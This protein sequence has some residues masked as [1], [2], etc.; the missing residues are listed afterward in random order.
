MVELVAS[1]ADAVP[2]AHDVS[3]GGV[4]V[5]LA[6]ISIASQVG[7]DVEVGPW[8]QMFSE[9]PHRVVAVAGSDRAETLRSAASAR[10]VEAAR[11]G[12]VGGDRITIACDEG[13]V[14][15]GVEEASTA[16]SEAIPRRLR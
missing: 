3:D 2:V 14:D 10:G 15:I 9:D 12:T 5:A 6:E 1:M 8:Q 13:R 11:I 7:I 4:A 16:H